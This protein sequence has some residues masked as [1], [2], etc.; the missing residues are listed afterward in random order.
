MFPSYNNNYN[1]SSDKP[2]VGDS[3]V[4]IKNGTEYHGYQ[5]YAGQY[6][7]QGM[8]EDAAKYFQMSANLRADQIKALPQLSDQG[9]DRAVEVN[10]M[11]SNYYNGLANWQNAPN[12][13]M[14]NVPKA[15]SYGLTEDFVN[16]LEST[17]KVQ[18]GNAVKNNKLYF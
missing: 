6:A 8:Y 11:L 1:W 3:R 18:F 16:K 2:F 17:G 9:H 4:P 13:N 15:A 7:S 14:N 12:V 10:Q 5:T